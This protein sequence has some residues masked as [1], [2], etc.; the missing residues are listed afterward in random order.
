[1]VRFRSRFKFSH[2]VFGFV[3]CERCDA[4]LESGENNNAIRLDRSSYRIESATESDAAEIAALYKKVWDEYKGRFPQ[5]LIGARQ[6]S[7]EQ[8]KEWMRQDAYF[9]AR[10]GSRIV[11]VMGCS[12][13]HGTC[14]LMHMVVDS[15]YR[16]RG[17]GSALTEK[18]IRY[19][20]ENRATKVW[21]DTTP[22]LNEAMALYQ[23]H[24]F[25]RC[26]RLRKHYWGEDIYF[27]E[28]MLQSR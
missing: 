17:I 19:A 12:L 8:M 16:K 4:N 13:R 11:G 27:Y 20:R 23:K 7:V 26:G 21:L 14:L 15:G 24:G 18:A 3:V 10:I 28:L 9:V 25:V 2:S 5:E 22:R 6:P 1:M